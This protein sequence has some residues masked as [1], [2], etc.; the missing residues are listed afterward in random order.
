MDSQA[1]HRQRRRAEM[2][3]RKRKSKRKRAERETQREG[4]KQKEWRADVSE[5]IRS[6]ENRYLGPMT[7]LCLALRFEGEALNCCHNDKALNCCHN[8]KAS[9][10]SLSNYQSPFKEH[11]KVDSVLRNLSLRQDGTRLKV[12]NMH[13]NC[14]QAT[15]QKQ[16]RDS[17][18]S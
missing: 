5:A 18:H 6:R 1:R 2:R 17:S 4:V 3:N 13:Q 10:P 11:L 14:I 16:E 12:T 8:D 9:L 7:M 15:I